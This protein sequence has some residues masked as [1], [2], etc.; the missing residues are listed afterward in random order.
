MTEVI[1]LL[2]AFGVIFDFHVQGSWIDFLILAGLGSVCFCLLGAAVAAR[3][4]QEEAVA[5]VSNMF[6]M[7]MMF[8]SGVYFKVENFPPWLLDLVTWLPLTALN[9]GMRQIANSGSALGDMPKV[10][11][12][13]AAWIAACFLFLLR[14]F[15]W[16]LG[17]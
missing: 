16:G 6:F 12:V 13:L 4:K 2:L 5:G 1:F 10:L 9:E 11:T 3:I 17:D 7:S 14:G 8:L 15:D